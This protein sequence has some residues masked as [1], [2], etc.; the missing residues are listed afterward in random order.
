MAPVTDFHVKEKYS[1][2]NGLGSYHSSEAIPG[3]NPLVNN[4][5]QKPPYGLRTERISGTSFTAPREQN[6]QTWLYRVTSSLEQSEFVPIDK[7]PAMPS[8]ISPN[9]YMWPSF[10]KDADADWT[11]QKLLA[12]NGD[13]NQKQ[14]LSI[15]VFAIDKSMEE[16]QAFSSPDGDILIIPQAGTLDIQ[17]EMGKLLVRQNE[18]VVI[19]RGVRHRVTLPN[20]PARGYICE[21]F[22]GHFKL[23]DLG[24]VGSTGLANV[25]DFQIPTAFFEGQLKGEIA[26]AND[27]GEWTITS[28]MGGRLWQCRQDHT[29]F[30]VAAWHGTNYPYK[31][32]LARFN[33]LGNALFDEHDPSLYVVL[34]APAHGKEPGTGVVDFAVIPPRWMVSEDT[35]WLPYYHRNTMSEFYG[36][37]INAQD[38]KHP[39]NAASQNNSFFPFGA[40]L[41]GGNVTHGANEDDFQKASNDELKPTKVMN[42][43]MS[44]MLLETELP[45]YLSDW[46]DQAAVKNFGQNKPTRSKM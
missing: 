37:I 13:P 21:L 11:K 15:W 32:D 40:G 16:R 35:L 5:P 17:T 44:I 27:G 43:G 7:A 30:D 1:Y 31:Y 12:R 41:N 26:Q 10:Q 14:G 20:G 6:L 4:S 24:I 42:D 23:P 25:R 22:Q 8:N 2:L 28:R 34:T 29:P 38:P 19:P 46:A 45:L 39:L 36:P 33:V 9:S 18:I 3:A